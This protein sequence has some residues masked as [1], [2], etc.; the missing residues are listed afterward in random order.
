MRLQ[1]YNLRSRFQRSQ[2]GHNRS[3]LL[4]MIFIIRT[5]K[6]CRHIII[7]CNIMR[8]QTITLLHTY[9]HSFFAVRNFSIKLVHW[10]FYIRIDLLN[11]HIQMIFNFCQVLRKYQLSTFI[12]IN[13]VL[14]TIW[15]FLSQIKS[16]LCIGALPEVHC[17]ICNSHLD[18]SSWCCCNFFHEKNTTRHD[19]IPFLGHY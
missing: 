12:H 14:Y 7:V 2:F 15:I 3:H 18:R 5:C 6:I 10:H 4:D 9:R 11:R 1:K 16:R 17:T 19:T 8:L 13:Q